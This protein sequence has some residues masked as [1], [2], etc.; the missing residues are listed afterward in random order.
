[1]PHIFSRFLLVTVVALVLFLEFE[2]RE[3]YSAEMTQPP[4]PAAQP[5]K[6]L[7][8]TEKDYLE[9]GRSLEEA[10][11]K[12]DQT[13]VSQLVPIARLNERAI[14][15]LELP[16]NVR[17]ALLSRANATR[18]F[19]ERVLAE[20]KN[21]G[22][23]SLLRTREVDG[24]Q[25]VLMRQ[26]GG[27][28]GVNYHDYLLVRS[29][30]GKVV[31]EDLFVLS[32]G[33]MCSQTYRREFLN[34]LAS[35][36]QELIALKESDQTY[37][38]N[39][40]EVRKMLAA[41]RDGQSKEVLKIFRKLPAEL[42]KDKLLQLAAI[43]ATQDGE[44]SEYLIELERFRKSNPK[45]AAID[46][47]SVDFYIL[48]KQYDLALKSID[49]VDKF[50]G[51]DPFLKIVK[52]DVLNQMGKKAEAKMLIEM[53]IK[54]DPKLMNG[55]W[56]RVSISLEEKNHV[57]TLTW[58]KKIEELGL[59]RINLDNIKTSESYAEFVKSLEFQK[60]KT[61]LADRKR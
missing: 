8:L 6:P 58:L 23:Y 25:R 21:G 56:I 28:G 10:A 33:E 17:K 45:D 26:I 51:G 18:G 7:P 9:F 16:E 20:V 40:S 11:T 37:L 32:I 39:I 60:L 53:G 1:M 36:K 5:T 4:A 27:N 57:D 30:D 35:A 59:D 54:D 19:T 3:L 49:Q 12:N 38:D 50:V 41:M 31:A 2:T 34:I 15:D 46:L 24:R 29:P 22:R 14:R 52:G 61:W 55:Y 13:T 43:K 47:F 44:E 48:K 42:Q